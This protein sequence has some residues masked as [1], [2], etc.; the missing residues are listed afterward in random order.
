MYKYPSIPSHS[1]PTQTQTLQQ[2]ATA[3]FEQ[4]E[5]LSVP[6]PKSLAAVYWSILV[7]N[8]KELHALVSFPE[9]ACRCW[10]AMVTRPNLTQAFMLQGF[11]PIAAVVI[12]FIIIKFAVFV[13]LNERKEGKQPSVQKKQS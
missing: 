8:M 1:W 6:P 10:L 12:G 4:A 7:E 5:P 2:F 13:Y 9:Q 11:V 3:G